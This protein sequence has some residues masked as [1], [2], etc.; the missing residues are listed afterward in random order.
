MDFERV[1]D[2]KRADFILDSIVAAIPENSHVL[3]VGCGNGIISRLL[4]EKGFYVTAID[5]SDKTIGLARLRNYHPLIE[6]KVVPAGDLDPDPGKFEAIVCSEVLEHL[7]APIDLLQ[8][9]CASLTPEGVI[10]V[11]VPNGRGPRELFVT[12]PVQALREKDNL[13]WRILSRLKKSMGYTGTTI[14]S[15]VDDLTH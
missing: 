2:K 1:A 3:D 13:L 7:D 14:Q 8:V 4:A 11:T 15:S 10:V 12:R 5:V 9:L 6:Y